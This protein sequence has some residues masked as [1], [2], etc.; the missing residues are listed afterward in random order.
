[1]FSTIY[2]LS[3]I[4]SKIMKLIQKITFCVYTCP[5]LQG[6]LPFIWNMAVHL[7]HYENVAAVKKLS[8]WKLGILEKIL[9]L[10]LISEIF[11]IFLSVSYQIE[12]IL[13]IYA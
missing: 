4:H 8:Q 5:L 9:V 3:R 1:M 12:I 13:L 6:R 10:I 2:F 11:H 7:E